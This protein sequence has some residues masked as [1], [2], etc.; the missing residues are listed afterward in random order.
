MENNTIEATEATVR[1]QSSARR[2][3]LLVKTVKK[4]GRYGDGN[5]L[6]LV[7][8]ARGAKRWMLRVVAR[9]KRCDLGLGSATLVSLVMCA[10]KPCVCGRSRPTV[11]TRPPNA[12]ASASR[13]RR[14]SRP[15][16]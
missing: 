14:S 16:P 6:Y 8:D 7:V 5:G 4:P 9:G 11:E 10:M 15:R 13:F 12:V 1:K 3:A 2:T